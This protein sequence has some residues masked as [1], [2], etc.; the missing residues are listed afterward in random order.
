[1][2]QQRKGQSC[3]YVGSYGYCVLMTWINKL[4]HTVV[5][6]DREY[7]FYLLPNVIIK[8]KCKSIISNGMMIHLVGLFDERQKNEAK[9]LMNGKDCLLISKRAHILFDFYQLVDAN[10]LLFHWKLSGYLCITV[11]T[12]TPQSTWG[13]GGRHSKT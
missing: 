1:M 8:C 11:V 13:G 7:E 3:R 12:W 4:G 2:G 9:G 6:E 5:V 10:N